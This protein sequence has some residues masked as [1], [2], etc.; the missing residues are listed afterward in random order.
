MVKWLNRA[1]E[2]LMKGEDSP[3]KD[4][5][6]GSGRVDQRSDFWL[7]YFT[8]MRMLAAIAIWLAV[9][10]HMDGAALDHWTVRSMASNASARSVTFGAGRFVAAGNLGTNLMMSSEDG[11]TWTIRSYPPDPILN[12]TFGDGI[13]VGV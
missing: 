11:I 7:S 8:M 6:R 9:V 12:V 10:G 13:F 5:K 4:A 2:E 3:P 1:A